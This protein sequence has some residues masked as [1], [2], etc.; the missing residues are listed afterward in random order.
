MKHEL[1]TESHY[2]DQVVRGIKKFEIRKNDR[3]FESGDI[4]ILKEVDLGGRETGEQRTVQIQYVFY[5]GQHGLSEDYC[6]F[7]W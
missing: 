6:I 2:F 4:V 7:N 1:K 5:G 3:E